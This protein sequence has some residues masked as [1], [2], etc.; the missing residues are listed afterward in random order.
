MWPSPCCGKLKKSGKPKVLGLPCGGQH[1][2]EYVLRGMMWTDNYWL[3]CENKKRLLCMVNDIIEELLDL[4]MEPKTESLWWTSTCKEEEKNTLQ[5]GCRTRVWEL[6]LREVFKILGYRYH[7]DGKGFQGAESTTCKGMG[8]LC[9]GT[10]ICRSKT[11]PMAAKCK[12]VHGHVYSTVLNGSINW[13]WSGATINTVRAWE[14]KILRLTFRP[15]RKLD[16]TWV[17]YK[18]STS[19]AL[20]KSWRKV[21]LPLLTENGE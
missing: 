15:G 11:V 8:S 19:R 2:S 4:D 6:P 16:E 5:V 18:I 17:G 12:R 3:F 13:P 7:R 10:Y 21:G 14:A 20:R 1:D 9:R